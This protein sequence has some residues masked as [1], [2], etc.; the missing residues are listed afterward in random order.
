MLR[1]DGGGAG[2]REGWMCRMSGVLGQDGGG[3]REKGRVDVQED[4][5]RVQEEERG[6]G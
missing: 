4:E 5:G 1:E 3:C 6:G 2:G